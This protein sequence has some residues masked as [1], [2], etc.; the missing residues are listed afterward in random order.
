MLYCAKCRG[1]CQDS[2]AKCPN[3]ANAKLRQVND[4][5]FVL[6]HHAD[7]YSAQRLAALFDEHSV[8]Y[9]MEEFGKGRISY[10][11]DSEVMPTDRNITVKYRDM[12]TA[13]GLSAQLRDELEQEQAREDGEEEFE[14]MPQKK[15]ILVQSLSVVAFLILVMLVVF[16]ADALANWLKGLF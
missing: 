5:D 12:P 7:Q 10:L 9:R 6:L 15:R 16:G 3:C 1:I 13:Q 2:T 8:E 11:Y 14:D 4:E